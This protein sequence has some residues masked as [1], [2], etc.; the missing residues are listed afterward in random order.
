MTEKAAV[1]S[2]AS[3]M[4]VTQ[5]YQRLLGLSFTVRPVL[6]VVLGV[7]AV[8]IGSLLLIIFLTFLGRF[9]GLTGPG[10]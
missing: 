10:R 8:L 7:C 3:F 1:R 5:V 4:G 9:A 2:A 6:K